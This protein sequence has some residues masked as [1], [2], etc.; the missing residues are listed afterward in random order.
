M[1]LYGKTIALVLGL[2]LPGAPA[3]AKTIALTGAGATFPY[4][5]YSKW[6]AV[7]QK[8][9][10]KVEF[11]YQSIGSG[12]GQRQ[13]LERT[14]DFGASD[15]PMTDAMMA[16]APGKLVHLPM[17]LGAVVITY[18][19]PG[20]KSTLRLTGPLVAD[21]YL[22]KVARWNDPEIAAVNPAV[23][24]PDTPITVVHRADG[25]GTTSVFTSYLAK[26]S[27]AWRDQVGSGVS[28]AWPAG[29]GGKGNEGVTGQVRGTPGSIGYV[30]LAYAV[31]NHLPTPALK[32]RA[33]RFVEP[34]IEAISA[35]A[36]GGAKE[37]PEDFR[38]DLTDPPGP[39]AYPICSFTYLLVYENGS[40]RAKDSALVHFVQWAIHEGQRLGPEL[41]YAPLPPPVVKK[42][43]VRLRTLKSEG[44]GIFE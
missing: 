16:K 15:A 21:L 22:G 5:L 23:K 11:N 32:N 9:H 2:A 34:S 12:A 36:A 30:E 27:P 17:T 8:V 26:V 29:L 6:F 42:I 18:N 33:G 38:V 40:N 3:G 39:E 1:N 10:P 14:V 44:R 31:Q 24:L 28:V 13:I 25:S 41:D 35:A 19:L 4:P 20:V 37:M 43:D 7:Y